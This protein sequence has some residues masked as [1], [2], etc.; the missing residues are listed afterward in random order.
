MLLNYILSALSKPEVASSGVEL[1]LRLL[2]SPEVRKHCMTCIT[3]ARN[4]VTRFRWWS[5]IALSSA[6]VVADSRRRET[7]ALVLRARRGSPVN[8]FGGR[9]KTAKVGRKRKKVLS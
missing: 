7:R 6:A 2:F 4:H 5:I 8:V 9:N 3:F 1:C